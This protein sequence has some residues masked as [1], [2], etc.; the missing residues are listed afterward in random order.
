MIAISYHANLKE[1]QGDP[2]LAALLG[3]DAPA[4]FDRLEWWSNLCDSFG[5]TPLIAVARTANG[6]LVLPLRRVGH[7]IE[8]LTCWY[9]FRVYPLFWGELD[10]RNDEPWFLLRALVRDLRRRTARL[11]LAPLPDEEYS[12]TARNICSALRA[13][14]WSVTSEQCDVN[15]VLSVQGRSYAEFLASRPGQLRTT[16]KRK[17][18]RVETTI[19]QTFADDTWHAYESVYRA[20]WKPEEGSFAFLR[21]FAEAEAASGRMR[22]GIASHD[23]LPVAAQLWT[24]DHGTAYIHK[25]AHTEESKPLSPGTTLSAALFQHVI[26]VDRAVLVDF[27]TGDDPYKRDWMDTVRPRFR[28]DALNPSAPRAWPYIARRLLRLAP[29]QSHG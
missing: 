12:R 23:G 5:Y 4:P 28:I 17:S 18:G 15:H 11:T 8:A 2:A 26:D 13:E 20:S 3:E 29:G 7:R 27:G 21:S 16:L 1:V 14:G 6:G 22:L 25:L 24:V 10:Y 19:Y 9:T